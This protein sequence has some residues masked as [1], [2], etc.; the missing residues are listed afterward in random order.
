VD[1]PA[2][3][4]L[5]YDDRDIPFL[6]EDQQDA[7]TIQQTQAITIRELINAG[8]DPETVIKAV[9]SPGLLVVEAFGPVSVQLQEPGSTST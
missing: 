9:T 3:A 7:A 6:Q 8:Y 4:D 1:V 2:G 5:W